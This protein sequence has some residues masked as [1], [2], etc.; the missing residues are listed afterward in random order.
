[1][2][3]YGPQLPSREATSYLACLREAFRFV[4]HTQFVHILCLWPALSSGSL[5]LWVNTYFHFN[6]GQKEL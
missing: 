1:M 5:E 6:Y 3:L 2:H 4:K